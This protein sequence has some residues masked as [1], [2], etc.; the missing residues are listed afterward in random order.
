MHLNSAAADDFEQ[1]ALVQGG[2]QP[3]SFKT[4]LADRLWS[5][6]GGIIADRSMMRLFLSCGF[7]GRL[8]GLGPERAVVG[9]EPPD[10]SGQFV[11]HDGHR[12]GM[13]VPGLAAAL[14]ATE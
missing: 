3:L 7:S 6:K 14:V 2:L 1:I 10:D 9:E 8:R 5:V 11:G 12:R 4:R 13:V